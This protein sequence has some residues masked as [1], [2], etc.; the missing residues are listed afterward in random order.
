MQESTPLIYHS[1]KLPFWFLLLL[2]PTVLFHW[3]LNY[4]SDNSALP[5]QHTVGRRPIA[6]PCISSP[7]EVHLDAEGVLALNA[8]SQKY[9]A[10]HTSEKQLSTTTKWWSLYPQLPRPSGEM[11]LSQTFHIGCQRG[12]HQIKLLLSTS[13]LLD[14]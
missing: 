6:S 11:I 3:L 8:V 13:H 1:C 12:V 9:R 10:A 4:D 2:L 7:E 5:L 14:C